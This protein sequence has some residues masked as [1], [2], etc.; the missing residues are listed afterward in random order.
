M[1]SDFAIPDDE[2]IE[3]RGEDMPLLAAMRRALDAAV[4]VSDCDGH[5]IIFLACA[6][7]AP[8]GRRNSSLHDR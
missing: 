5:L 1:V 4:A 2:A 3:T 6:M 7:R 8:P